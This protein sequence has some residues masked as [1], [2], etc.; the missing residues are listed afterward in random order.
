M[1]VAWFTEAAS[2]GEG[3]G[4]VRGFRYVAMVMYAS[5]NGVE[6]HCVQSARPTVRQC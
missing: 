1:I 5:C 4:Q 3:F 2:T 6:I